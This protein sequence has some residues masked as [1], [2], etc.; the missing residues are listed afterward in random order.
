M[1]T[2]AGRRDRLAQA[3]RERSERLKEDLRLGQGG[4]ASP[5]DLFV[6][7]ATADLPVEWAVLERAS[8]GKLLAVPADAGPRAGSAD[9]EVSAQEPGGPLSLR[10]RFANRL[11]ARLF[12]PE[13]RTGRLADETVA[14]ALHRIRQFE[15]GTLEPSPLAEEVDADPEYQDW[16]RDVLEPARKRGSETALRKAVPSTGGWTMTRLAAALA[17]VAVGLGIWVALLRR[18]VDRLSEPIFNPPSGEVMVGGASRGAL[19]LRVPADASHVTLTIV[20]DGSAPAG[21]G[22]LEIVRGSGEVVWRSP[23]IELTPVGAFTLTLP[24][25]SLPDGKY[26]VRIYPGPDFSG[27]PWEEKLQVETLE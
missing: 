1:T 14:E 13:L 4:P 10:C 5:G 11:D 27:H 20:V 12:D 7:K 18:E 21:P 16:T 2:D 6:L 8:G 15:S 25:R 22:R 23:R 17:L 9:V 26:R 24:R 3:A 19:E